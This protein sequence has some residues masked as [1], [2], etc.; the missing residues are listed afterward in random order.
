VSDGASAGALG[1][2]PPERGSA[3]GQ[4]DAASELDLDR[5][6]HELRTPLAAIQSTADALA[7]GHL[8]AIDPRHAAYLASI[9]DTARHALAVIGGMLDVS[10]RPS[11]SSDA[12]SASIDLE[13][14]AAEVAGAMAMLAARAGVGLE[15]PAEGRGARASASVTDVRQMLINLISNGIAHAGG[16]ATVRVTVGGDDRSEVWVDVTDNGPGLPREIVEQ[17][18][19]GSVLDGGA[20]GDATPRA[21]LGLRLTRHLA[22]ANGGRLEIATGPDGTRARVLLPA[23]PGASPVAGAI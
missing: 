23:A 7:S 21:R 11:S 8:G 5:L 14:I 12:A 17:L 20:E 4:R 10:G 22:A 16:G 1:A 9:R 18:E 6:A 19:A 15:A 3:E 2:E 13:A